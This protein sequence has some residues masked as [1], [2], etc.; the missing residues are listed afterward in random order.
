MTD[1]TTLRLR[2]PAFAAVTDATIAYWLTDAARIVTD[3][4]GDDQE[5]ATLALAAHNMS[6]NGAP[7]I[8]TDEVTALAGSGLTSF[9]SGT[10]SA[11]FSEA[12]A[13][14]AS[15]GGYAATVYGREFAI[16]L[17]RNV[18]GPRLVGGY[19]A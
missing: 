11:Q 6:I 8:A 10:F 4:W 2:Y 3:A 19:C 14:Q 5:P 17:R 13:A 1:P 12:A 18:G 9:K 7:G 15:A 16:M